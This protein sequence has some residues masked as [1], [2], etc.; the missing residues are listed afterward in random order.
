[1][2]VMIGGHNGWNLIKD[3][4]KH[5]V[6]NT[7]DEVRDFSKCYEELTDRPIYGFFMWWTDFNLH[8][9]NYSTLAQVTQCP[10]PEITKL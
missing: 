10:F 5:L 1:M 2:W 9:L 8:F 3:F 6:E 7:P 4:C